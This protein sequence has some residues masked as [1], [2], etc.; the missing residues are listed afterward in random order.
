[1]NLLLTS[2]GRRGYLVQYFKQALGDT[3]KV[4]ASNSTVCPAFYYAD[5]YVVSPLIH[6]SAYIPFLLDYCYQKDINLVVPIFDVDLPVLAANKEKFE[7]YGI[8]CAVSNHD[9]I[10]VCND[11]YNTFHFCEK[12]GLAAPQTFLYDSECLAVIEKFQLSYPLIVKPRW[13]MGSLSVFEA[14]N[15]TEL[16]LFVE[17]AKQQISKS[18][19]KHEAAKALE[20]CII[21][22]E[23]LDGLEFHLDVIND[24]DG[25]YQTTIAKQKLGMR[26]G[27]T[28]CAKIVDFPELD[29]IGEKLSSSL[30]HCGNLDVDII[31]NVGKPHIL[32]LNGRIGGGYPFSHMAGADL[33]RAYIN[34]A[35][36]KP[37]NSKLFSVVA[38][39]IA[40]KDIMM[41]DMTRHFGG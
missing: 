31:Y 3:G 18:Y 27:E 30:R 6:D 7:K 41:I 17:K 4:Y 13:G 19:L 25:N 5:E 37:V 1:M 21:I 34:W 11:K 23:K 40:Q 2:A 29:R 9:V 16:L 39:I 36:G 12:Q 8:V 26:S 33:P 15:E 10:D 20:S 28:D 22:Q 38:G 24:F 32:E 14:E 35:M